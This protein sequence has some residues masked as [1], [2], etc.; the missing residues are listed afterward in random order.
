M[1]SYTDRGQPRH[2]PF[3]GN[4]R[5][6]PQPAHW[7]I[8]DSGEGKISEPTDHRKL[9]SDKAMNSRPASLSRRSVLRGRL[10]PARDDIVVDMTAIGGTG[11]NEPGR[12]RIKTRCECRPVQDRQIAADAR[13]RPDEHPP[14]SL[15]RV[16]IAEWKVCRRQPRNHERLGVV[17]LIS[18]ATAESG[19]AA[20]ERRGGRASTTRSGPGEQQD[21]YSDVQAKDLR[22]FRRPGGGATADR[23]RADS[24][25][26]MVSDYSTT[27][28]NRT[29]GKQPL[30]REENSG[31]GQHAAAAISEAAKLG[32]RG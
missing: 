7:R 25:H 32:I 18:H 29:S 8:L 30:R 31:A 16:G 9:R 6:D 3:S 22:S 26:N 21:M 12:D 13:Q 17:I 14:G 27:N 15:R 11:R 20:N 24:D 10:A 5:W 2:L 1:T 4:S 19:G 28:V 23:Y